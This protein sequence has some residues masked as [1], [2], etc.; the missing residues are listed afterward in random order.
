MMINDPYHTSIVW[1]SKNV[2]LILLN[3]VADNKYRYEN[4]Y[5]IFILLNYVADNSFTLGFV[6]RKSQ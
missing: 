2:I 3:Y 1:I 4:N 5:V 6:V